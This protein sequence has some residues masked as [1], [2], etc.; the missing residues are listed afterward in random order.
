MCKWVACPP[1]GDHPNPGIKL[2]SPA[3]PAFQADS[4]PTE[5]PGKFP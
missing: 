5:P 1:P 3:P 4:L 2:M